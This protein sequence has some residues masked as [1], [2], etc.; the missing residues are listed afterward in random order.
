MTKPVSSFFFPDGNFPV[1]LDHTFGGPKLKPYFSMFFL[2]FFDTMRPK[3]KVPSKNSPSG[4]CS[5]LFSLQKQ[6]QYMRA[7]HMGGFSFIDVHL[8]FQAGLVCPL[9]VQLMHPVAVFPEKIDMEPENPLLEKKPSS[10][11]LFEKG[12]SMLILFG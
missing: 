9:V 10:C 7:V 5:G 8:I 12:R 1:D 3:E 4:D 2:C 11:I 6:K